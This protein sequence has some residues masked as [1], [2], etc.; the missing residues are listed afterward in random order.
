MSHTIRWQ[1]SKKPRIRVRP[2]GSILTAQIPA[3]PGDTIYSPAGEDV[4]VDSI[5]EVENGWLVT[6]HTPSKAESESAA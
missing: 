3:L 2:Q 6:A 1:A 5:E 4:I